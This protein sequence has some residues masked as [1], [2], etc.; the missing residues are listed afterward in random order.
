MIFTSVGRGDVGPFRRD[1]TNVHRTADG[2]VAIGDGARSAEPDSVTQD[3]Q[4]GEQDTRI[5]FGD[6]A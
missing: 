5:E 1:G 4:A 2:L 3:G 6:G